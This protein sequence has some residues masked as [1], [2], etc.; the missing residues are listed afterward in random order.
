M[1]EVD[2]KPQG[3]ADCNPAHTFYQYGFVIS[4]PWMGPSRTTNTEPRPC[5]HFFNCRASAPHNRRMTAMGVTTRKKT[6][7][8]TT[9]DMTRLNRWERPN[10]STARGRK[11]LGH[12]M[13]SRSSARLTGRNLGNL[14]QYPRSRQINTMAIPVSLACSLVEDNSQVMGLGR[15]SFSVAMLF[16]WFEKFKVQS[17]KSERGPV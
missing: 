7:V 9:R 16:L 10:Q 14:P 8:R 3:G 13:V 4:F 2:G 6:T 12:T 17:S 11:A 1:N 15:F 5:F